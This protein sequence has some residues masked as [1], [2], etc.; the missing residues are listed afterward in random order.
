[1]KFARQEMRERIEGAGPRRRQASAL[2]IAVAAYLIVSN[3]VNEGVYAAA[4]L[5]PVRAI[6]AAKGNEHHQ[7]LMRS[8]C[9]HLMEFLDE[10]G[11]LTRPARLFYQRVSMV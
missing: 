4:G 7:T 6:A 9:A 10:L 8:S 5:D 2:V 3:M 1:M 11:L